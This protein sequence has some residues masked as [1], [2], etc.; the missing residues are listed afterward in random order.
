MLGWDGKWMVNGEAEEDKGSRE[1][2]WE[3][4]PR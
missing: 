2:V 1:A 4:K 3:V